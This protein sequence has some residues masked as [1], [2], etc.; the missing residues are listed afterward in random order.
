MLNVTGR[1]IA[2]LNPNGSV[3][4][5]FIPTTGGGNERPVVFDTVD[6]AVNF[7]KTFLTLEKV[8][9][10]RQELQRDKRADTVVE[11][12]ENLA[13]TFRNQPLRVE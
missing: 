12:G 9:A 4:M 8:A 11:M 10:M 6:D 13:G 1:F 5:V 7:V 2:D 3:R